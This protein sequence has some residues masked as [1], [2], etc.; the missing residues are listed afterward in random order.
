MPPDRIIVLSV[1]LGWMSFL[2]HIAA[3]L[4]FN[5][6]TAKGLSRPNT[7]TWSIWAFVTVLNCASYFMMSGDWAKSL[8]PLAGALACVGTLIFALRRGKLA[9]PGK[10]D[11]VV[12]AIG[13]LSALVWFAYRDAT[14]ANLILQAGFVLSFVPTLRDVWQRPDRES[15]LPWF[16]WGAAYLLLIAVVALRWSGRWPDLV[17]PVN[18]FFWH[19]LVGVIAWRGRR[20]D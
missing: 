10:A 7:A 11:S 15:P 13:L 17:Y 3:F 1:A 19:A 5:W 9:R 18:S 4:V 20:K 6:K 16:M 2:V 12:L 8:Q 14:S